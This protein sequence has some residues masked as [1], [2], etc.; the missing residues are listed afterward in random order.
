MSASRFASC[1]SAIAFLA[2][3][4]PAVHGQDA[5]VLRTWSDPVKLA[6]GTEAVYRYEVSYDYATGVAL[7]RA[8]DGDVLVEALEIAPPSAPLPQEIAEAR[9][10]V[11]ADPEISALAARSGATIEGGFIL[12]GAQH[13]ACAPPAR[14]LQF[15]V[16]APDRTES[17]Q[18][19]VVDL[20]TRTIIERDLFPD[21]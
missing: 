16:M 11:E 15:D 17:L 18:F 19:V 13:A 5:R 3:A 10:L 20:R 7:R 12:F 6:D 9:A 8:Y 21:L 2:L 1:L 4:V 14:C